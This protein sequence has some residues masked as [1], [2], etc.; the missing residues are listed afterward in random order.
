MQNRVVVK[1]DTPVPA[2]RLMELGGDDVGGPRHILVTA[3]NSTVGPLIKTQHDSMS[4]L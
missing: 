2:A 4:R 3:K 1:V